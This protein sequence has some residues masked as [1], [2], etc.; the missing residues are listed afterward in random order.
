MPISFHCRNL[1]LPCLLAKREG[2]WHLNATLAE[3][4][5]V[6]FAANIAKKEAMS[7]FVGPEP[8]LGVSRVTCTLKIR[9]WLV[10]K[11][12]EKWKS[13]PALTHSKKFIKKPN[14]KIAREALSNDRKTIKTVIEAITGHCHLRKHMYQIG[15]CAEPDC[16]VLSE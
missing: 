4:V 15:I 6:C 8:A 2:F 12:A 14:K 10:R 5:G 1:G 13:L 7:C 16:R 3:R 9:E 11:H